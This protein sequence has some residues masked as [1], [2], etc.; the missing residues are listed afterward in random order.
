MTP[1]DF[2]GSGLQ[3]ASVNSTRDMSHCGLPI[4][5]LYYQVHRGLEAA[6]TQTRF[7][8]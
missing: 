2:C 7:L 8:N 4:A 1:R 5:R 3:A 6:P